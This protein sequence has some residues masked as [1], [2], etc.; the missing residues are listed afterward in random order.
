MKIN[1]H[2]RAR[3]CVRIYTRTQCEGMTEK[4]KRK[5]ENKKYTHVIKIRSSENFE[6]DFPY[7]LPYLFI[8]P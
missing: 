5:E 7:V 6:L 1:L 3:A 2:V 8:I 4:G